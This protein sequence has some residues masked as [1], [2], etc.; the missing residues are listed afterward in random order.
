MTENLSDTL[1]PVIKTITVP[2]TPQ[3]AFDYF[4]RDFAKWWP[5]HSHSVVAFASDF[6]KAPKGCLFET[7]KG[8]RIV[9]YGHAGEEYVWGK[10][11]N[12]DPPAHLA[13]TWHPGRDDVGQVVEIDFTKE[14]SGTRVVLTH[15]G[16]ELLGPGGAEERKGYHMGWEGV[17]VAAF[18]EF[19]S[20]RK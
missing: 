10:I 1:A 8:G 7:M 9:E 6:T 5:M 13:F 19:A 4:T 12:W 15:S 18:A 3:E 17:F 14:G 16:F 2:C 20:G 11:T